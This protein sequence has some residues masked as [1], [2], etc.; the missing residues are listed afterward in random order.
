M[1][2]KRRG[3]SL[4]IPLLALSQFGVASARSPK[5][6]VIVSDVRGIPASPP[7]DPRVLA[8]IVDHEGQ[9][10]EGI[11]V[12]VMTNDGKGAATG[13]TDAQGR[14]LLS[15]AVVGRVTIRAS[16]VGFITAE[17]RRVALERSNL[18]AVALPLQVAEVTDPITSDGS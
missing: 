2:I 11:A 8:I 15:V 9:P 10:L 13:A 16:H 12:S 14:A 17:A 6:N 7:S 5:A 4:A 18:T 1:A 3:W